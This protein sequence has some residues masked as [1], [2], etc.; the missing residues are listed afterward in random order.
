MHLGGLTRPPRYALR[1]G[2]S[3]SRGFTPVAMIEW[4]PTSIHYR[5][6]RRSP[7]DIAASRNDA[8]GLGCVKTRLR[9]EPIEW[10]FLGFRDPG[11]KNSQARSILI[12]RRKIILLVFELAGFSH[13][14]GQ[15]LQGRC[16]PKTLNVRFAPKATELPRRREM[17]QRARTRSRHR[18]SPHS[19]T[20]SARAE[21]PGG[22]SR[23]SAFALYQP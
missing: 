21:R 5:R 4:Q 7:C 20:L 3:T 6:T 9:G 2:L 12:E 17:S 1:G 8:L 16:T 23:P 18:A 13:S 11:C 22:T 14:Q 15:T 10:T 19:I